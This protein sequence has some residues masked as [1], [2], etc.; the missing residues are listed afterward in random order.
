MIAL[1]A[2][3]AL[4]AQ[5]VAAHPGDGVKDVTLDVGGLIQP[6]MDLTGTSLA[7]SFGFDRVRLD[8]GGSVVP[9]SGPLLIQERLIVE[10]A[11]ETH[12][13]DAWVQ[14]GPKAIAIRAGQMKT[15]FSR[16]GMSA[17]PKAM[18][19]WSTVQ[20][21]WIAKRDVGAMLN[22]GL[23]AKGSSSTSS[24]PSTATARTSP[25]TPTRA[26]CTSR[27]RCSRRPAAP[28]RSRSSST[29]GRL[30]AVN[31][32]RSCRSGSRGTAT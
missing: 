28:G 22:G 30:P 27:A 26:S 12:L 21:G 11:Q 3:S 20:G 7:P 15:P 13:L 18:L 32:V 29:S 1:W 4:A 6:R 10:F 16:N 14:V 2:A 31:R 8:I 24:A 23:G 17:D 9:E 5:V 25:A 19:P